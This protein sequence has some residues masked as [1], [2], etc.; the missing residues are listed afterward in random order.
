MNFNKVIEQVKKLQENGTK[1]QLANQ[2][3][4]VKDLKIDIKELDLKIEFGT[5]NA[6]VTAILIGII[7][8]ILGIIIKNQKFEIYPI[9]QDKNI[10][11][12]KLDCIFNLNLMQYIYKTIKKGR[13]ENERKSSD[14]R[15]Y[16]YSNE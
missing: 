11:N 10:L 15:S 2:L 13:K 4:G 8:S 3:I 9:Y 7:A 12:V 5:E 1:E 6:A 16:A 14:R